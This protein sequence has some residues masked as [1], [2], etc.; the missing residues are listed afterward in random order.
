MTVLDPAM[1]TGTFL[2]SVIDQ[3]AETVTK[4]RGDVPASLRSLLGRL[5]GFERQVG[6][7]AVA[8]LKLEQALEAHQ[9]NAGDEDF[10]LYVAD[11]LDDPNKVPLPVRGRL[12]AP[13]A[14]SR[15]AANQV[16]TNEDVMVVLGNPPY[17]TRAIRQGKWVLDKE[18]RQTSLP[19]DFKEVDHGKYESKLHDLAVYFWRWSL[20]KAFES[21][22]DSRGIVA[23]ITTS[24][25][26]DGPGFAGMR[27]YLGSIPTSA[28]LLTY[29][30]KVIGLLSGRASSRAFHIRF[31]LAY[32][33]VIPMLI[34]ILR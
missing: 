16:K 17:R 25:Y 21:T 3:V 34:I 27:R 24:A 7:Y 5:I 19:H 14:D 13:L 18:S 6:P 32:S 28:G 2:Q 23:F 4:D 8:E 30:Q 9:A 11:T 31:A 15:R 12:Y 1:G 22:S 29:H 26:L 10:R 20:W 33:L